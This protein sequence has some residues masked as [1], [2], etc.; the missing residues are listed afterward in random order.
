MTRT[1]RTSSSAASATDEARPH[2]V[3]LLPHCS[4]GTP[5]LSDADVATLCAW[6][7]KMRDTASMKYAASDL[8]P[9][10]PTRL[11]PSAASAA[12]PRC[13]LARSTSACAADRSSLADTVVITVY[14]RD[15][16][17]FAAMNET[18][19]QAWTGAPPP[20]PRSSPTCSR[21]AR[22]W[23]CPPLPCRPAPIARVVHPQSGWPAEPVLVRD[24]RRRHVVPVRADRAKRKG[25]QHGARRRRRA[26]AHRD[27]ERA[28]TAGSRGSELGASR[29][30]ARVSCP[31]W[32]TSRSSIACIA[33]TSA[34]IARRV[35]R[36]ARG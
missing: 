27:G 2:A 3:A 1:T 24:S 10:R 30:R 33:S 22:A 19:R 23:R 29:Q 7:D 9:R 16:A 25:Q 20:A 8:R 36:S 31:T 5:K 32:T 13:A 4:T 35:R 18:Y 12:R 17:D 15:A 26:D 11:T 21:P 14:L 34:R 28:G 6:S